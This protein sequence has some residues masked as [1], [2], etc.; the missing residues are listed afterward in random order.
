MDR[1]TFLKGTIAAGTLAATGPLVLRRAGAQYKRMPEPGPDELRI[2]ESA[3]RL[4]KNV[5]LSFVAWG[6]HSKGQMQ[7]LAA[8]FKKRTG[9]G[10]GSIVDI[11][12]AQLS[13]RAMAEAFA[14]SGKLDLLHVH[15]DTVPTL[16]TA[17]L[18][19]PLDDYMK[20]VDFDYTSVGTFVQMSQLNGKTYG[21]VTDGNCHTYLVRKD[22]IENP[23]NQ[24]RY[25]D[26]YGVP[27]RMPTTWKEY[28]RQ[29]A[30]FGSDPS[31]MT[32]FGSLRARRW[33]YWWFFINYYNHGL[34]PFTDDVEP[35]FDND[36]AEAALAAYLGE[37]RYVLRD[38][39]NWG[40]AQMWPHVGQGRAYQTIY[41][42][43]VIPLWESPKK[44]KVAGKWLH[45]V[46]P[47]NVL[48]GGRRIVRTIAAGPPLVV[49]NRYGKNIDAAAHLAM[50]W[51][52]RRNSAYLVGGVPSTVHDPWRA[53][54]FKDPAV[55]EVYTPAGTDAIALNMQVNSPAVRV[56][57]ALE[58]NDIL[59]KHV[60]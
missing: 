28:L 35:N 34:F 54:H 23:D 45:G 57:G 20:A 55:R 60:S 39:D 10:L 41:W 36:A 1:R 29:G 49:V 4:K 37:R 19:T 2:I 6:G 58:F 38:L 9:I 47:G 27:L 43:G 7:E 42:G 14:R 24:K 3:K 18:A 8:Y 12:F 52:A 59:D 21:L 13:Q 46:V 16:A 56:T 40:T 17:G 48:P 15:S 5:D 53:E 30:F 50:F 11:S 22:V 26:K 51:T 31:K 33:G 44:S 25:A 32:G